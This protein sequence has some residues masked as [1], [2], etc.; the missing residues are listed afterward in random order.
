LNHS[1]PPDIL[2]AILLGFVTTRLI[3]GV[4]TRKL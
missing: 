4:E 1:L 3:N 2:H